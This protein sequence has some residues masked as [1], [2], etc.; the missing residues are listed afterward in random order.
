MV[1]V[2][3]ASV[4]VTETVGVQRERE[5]TTCEALVLAIERT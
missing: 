3:Y 2:G 1:D 5:Y 4:V